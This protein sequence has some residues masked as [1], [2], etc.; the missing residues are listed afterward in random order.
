MRGADVFSGHSAL[1]G[2]GTERVERLDSGGYPRDWRLSPPPTPAEPN[3]LGCPPPT[4]PQRTK[5]VLSRIFEY[6]LLLERTNFESSVDSLY[7]AELSDALCSESLAQSFLFG[8][9]F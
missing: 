6:L 2:L 7:L 8:E 9:E 4:R 1:V 3:G 5:R